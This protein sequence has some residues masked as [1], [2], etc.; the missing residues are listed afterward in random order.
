MSATFFRRLLYFSTCSLLVFCQSC[1][2]QAGEIKF[3]PTHLQHYVWAPKGSFQMGC[4]LGDS[5]CA[6]TEKPAH[7]VTISRGFWIGQ[8]EVTVGAYEHFIESTRRKMP[9]EPKWLDRSLNPGWRDQKQPIV[10]VTWN[11]AQAFCSWSGGRLPTESEW[12]YA[13]RAGNTSAR[14]GDIGSVALYSDNSGN[15]PCDGEAILRSNPKDYGDALYKSGAHPHDVAQ[16]APN[17]WG[18]YDTLGNVW[19]W[20]DSSFTDGTQILR[21]GAY[22]FPAHLN[23]VS[24]KGSAPRLHRS[25]SIG[26]RC[27]LRNP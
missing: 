14:Y 13:S 20:T 21:G 6:P 5:E 19:E 7:E 10:H 23:R 2:R 3:G 9:P 25:T 22:S 16:K 8:T 18:M 12:E 26:F 24:A 17:H 1:F 4:S 15:V 11:D 27:V